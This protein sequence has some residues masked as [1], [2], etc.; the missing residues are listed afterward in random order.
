MAYKTPEEMVQLIIKENLLTDA[1]MTIVDGRNEYGFHAVEI[2]ASSIHKKSEAEYEI[3]V[4][5]ENGNKTL[6][7]AKVP[8]NGKVTKL[9]LI[10]S[11]KGNYDVIS[12]QHDETEEDERTLRQ[13]EYMSVIALFLDHF[14]IGTK[15]RLM[16]I[17]KYG[18]TALKKEIGEDDAYELLRDR[19]NNEMD[20]RRADVIPEKF[21][22]RFN[23]H[24]DD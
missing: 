1:C 4:M 7:P 16:N 3:E 24:V 9:W 18:Y 8:A 10:S 21:G 6:I 13:K 20:I 23:F 14:H 22:V 12:I 5:D 15:I 2:P 17:L 11:K 19:M